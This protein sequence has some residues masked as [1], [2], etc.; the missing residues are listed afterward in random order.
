MAT[1]YSFPFAEVVSC[2][3]NLSHSELSDVWWSYWVIVIF[4]SP[5]ETTVDQVQHG[6][7]PARARLLMFCLPKLLS[8]FLK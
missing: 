4:S 5:I 7:L 3:L 6:H 1:S 2:L 8:D